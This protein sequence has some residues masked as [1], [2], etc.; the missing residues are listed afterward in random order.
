MIRSNV[1]M[2]YSFGCKIEI[3]IKDTGLK[4]KRN[5][6]KSR[7]KKVLMYDIYE[8]STEK[9]WNPLCVIFNSQQE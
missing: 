9:D 6:K 4:K 1:A 8:G 2:S 7:F 5:N 3:E